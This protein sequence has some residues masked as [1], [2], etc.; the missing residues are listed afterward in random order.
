MSQENALGIVSCVESLA[1]DIARV[2]PDC[3]DKAMKIVEL[4]RELAAEPDRA[5]VQEALEA[6]LLAA[7]VSD[8]AIQVTTTAVVTAMRET[9][10]RRAGAESAPIV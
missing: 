1:T 3:A 7:D 10:E 8:S 9:D 2:S 6:N 5:T 4:V